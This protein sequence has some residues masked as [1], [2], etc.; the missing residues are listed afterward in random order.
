MFLPWIIG[1]LYHVGGPQV[2]MIVIA[3]DL[4][5]AMA[6]LVAWT[7]VAAPVDTTRQVVV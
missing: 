5:M 6:V 3:A 7:L 4:V 2:A 1:Q